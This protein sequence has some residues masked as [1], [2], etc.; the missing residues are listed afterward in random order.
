[1]HGSATVLAG[2]CGLILVLLPVSGLFAQESEAE[3]DFRPRIAIVP[4]RNDSGEPAYDAV[5]R[6]VSDSVGLVLRLLGDF[7][8]TEVYD[9]PALASVDI[10]D[11]QQ[12]ALLVESAPFEEVIYGNLIRN[13]QRQL[14]FRLNLYSAEEQGVRFAPTAV[15]RS[16]FAVFDAADEITVALVSEFSDVRVGFG[17]LEI[18]LVDGE[19]LFDV[20]LDQTRIR[21]PET[22]LQNVLNGSYELTIRQDRLLGETVIYR[23]QVEIFEDR[24][25][26]VEFA[27]PAATEE[28]I[29]F[30][31][32]RGEEL[33]EIA[34]NPDLI[35]D[36]ILDLAE[37]QAL[38]RLAGNDTTLQEIGSGVL[39]EATERTTASLET[40]RAEADSLY[41]ADNP[42][43]AAAE[44]VYQRYANLIA[45][46]FDVAITRPFSGFT[47]PRAVTPVPGGY[48][49]VGSG[50]RGISLFLLD[51]ELVQQ[52]V[53]T[54]TIPRNRY[55]SLTLD[56]ND[57]LHVT[58]T[59]AR[60]ILRYRGE[61]QELEAIPVNQ[62]LHNAE[63]NRLLAIAETGELYVL[64]GDQVMVLD[65]EGERD[66]AVEASF[67]ERLADLGGAPTALA[68]GPRDLLHI[69]S[70]ESETVIRVDTLG[71]LASTVTLPGSAGGTG[72]GVDD[73]G[74]IYIV[75]PV[76]HQVWRYG[77][78]GERLSVI[79]GFGTGEGEFRAPGGIHVLGDGTLVVADTFGDRLQVLRPTG[80]SIQS[81]AVADFG[82]DFQLRQETAAT[83]RQR[84]EIVED[85][86]RPARVVGSFTSGAVAFGLSLGAFVGADLFAGIADAAFADYTGLG[87][88]DDIASARA[89]VERNWLISRVILGG[90]VLGVGVTSYLL[91]NSLLL[92]TD[93][94][95]ARRTA[96]RELQ[97]FEI[98]TTYEVDP[99][100]WRSLRTA[101]RLGLITGV[102]PPVLG[103]GLV[104]YQTVI[105]LPEAYADY[106][107]PALIGTTAVPPVFGHL[108]GGRFHFGLFLAGLAAD[109][110]VIGAWQIS[111][112]RPAD[113]APTPLQV[114]ITGEFG[115]VLNGMWEQ[116]QILAPELLM[117]GGLGIRL[118]AGAY[119]ARRGWVQTRDRNRYQ[120]V[121]PVEDL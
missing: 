90:G 99:D 43:F 3:G 71:R 58:W 1:M 63:G 42:D 15:A 113:F 77:A 119:D 24:T 98:G 106:Y 121:R 2:L 68:Y 59:G 44:A 6:T 39:A 69:F 16:I 37:F 22:D 88:G 60:E 95:V 17:E 83:A 27:I 65:P 81:L 97:A 109:A 50:V 53:V 120:A 21:N 14:E 108:Y 114:E 103:I 25:T 89:D 70:S 57:V 40:L 104:G 107:Y 5:A 51:Q 45:A 79:G 56:P 29:S 19:G 26:R 87:L 11:Q 100:R 94:A 72:V 64:Q 110:L 20:F 10:E 36:A 38:T 41:Y 9:E 93:F 82:R 35:E 8:V 32:R 33:L 101:N 52:A 62:A 28:E 4:M 13:D 61:F 23:Q 49:L 85:S 116:A 96:V 117:L 112:N 54:P 34:Q 118:T 75:R 80:P 30:L 31:R 91:T 115:D 74:N 102:V 18:V 12:I 92:S 111:Q 66:A 48:V 7:A 84:M 47:Q 67:I 78:S 46:P 55:V 76:T 73:L 105:G 86:I